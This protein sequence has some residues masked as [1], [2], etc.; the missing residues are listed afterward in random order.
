[1]RSYRSE[2]PYVYVHDL[3]HHPHSLATL[4]SHATPIMN[5]VSFSCLPAALDRKTLLNATTGTE[6]SDPDVLATII[7]QNNLS[8][9]TMIDRGPVCHI[10]ILNDEHGTSKF[11]HLQT[12]LLRF[13]IVNLNRY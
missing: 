12:A 4:T 11:P 5:S 13:Y 10:Y 9:S 3:E 7:S 8:D 2:H 1:M 6:P